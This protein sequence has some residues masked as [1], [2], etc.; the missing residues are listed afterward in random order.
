[1][2]EKHKK[3]KQNNN[4]TKQT[5]VNTKHMDRQKQREKIESFLSILA[6]A[7]SEI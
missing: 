6:V 3:K 5:K 2:S 7:L 4:N 1:M